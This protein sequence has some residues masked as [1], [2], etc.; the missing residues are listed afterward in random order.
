MTQPLKSYPSTIDNTVESCA[1]ALRK[2]S[3]VRTD[4]Q[5]KWKQLT[6]QFILG[7][8]VA[9]VPANSADITGSIVGDFNVTTTFAYFCVNNAGT[10]QW[11]RVAVGTF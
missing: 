2:I 5:S 10:A 6:N 8:K 1:D 7:R 3:Q 4:D 11:V 9:K